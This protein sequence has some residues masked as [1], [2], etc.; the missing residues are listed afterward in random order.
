[1]GSPGGG[2]LHPQRAARGLLCSGQ[3]CQCRSG[4]RIGSAKYSAGV[5]WGLQPVQGRG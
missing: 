5:G 4:D 3:I 2:F 1:M